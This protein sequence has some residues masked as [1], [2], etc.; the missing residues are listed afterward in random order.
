MI[1]QAQDKQFWIE[2][3]HQSGEQL[4]KLCD[5]NGGNMRRRIRQAKELYPN[6]EW[7][8]GKPDTKIRKGIAIYDLHYPSHHK[9]LWSNFLEFVSDFQPDY[10]VFGGD[11]MDFEVIS[12]WIGDKRRPVEGKRLRRDYRGFNDNILK[13]LMDALPQNCEKTYLFGNHEDWVEQYIDS[14]PELEGFLEIENNLDLD[15]WE[16]I[17]YSK[18]KEIGKLHFI[19]GEYVNLH[20]AYKTAQ[21]YGRN[22]IYGHGHSFQAHTLTHPLDA[23]AYMGMQ[24][25]CACVLNPH[26]RLNKPNAWVNGFGAF[27]MQPNGMFNLFPVLSQQDGSF[28]APTGKE[29]KR[30]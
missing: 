8:G 25:P 17:P 24:L 30:G 29:Y 6:L 3:C 26:Y 9:A 5:T 12:H 21:V 20:N 14:H 23:D 15:D 4:A 13:P 16:V 28:V 11:N 1:P 18:S 22:I 19:H 10:F 27:Y 7:F 2:H